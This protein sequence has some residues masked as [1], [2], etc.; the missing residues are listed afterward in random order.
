MFSE[1]IFWTSFSIIFYHYVIFILIIFIL[2]E[3]KRKMPLKGNALPSV[4]ILIAA[5]NEE[6][7]IETKILN[8]LALDYPK[9]KIEIIVIADGSSDQT[10]SIVKKY[11]SENVIGLFETERRG[12]SMAINRGVNKAKGDVLFFTDANTILDRSCLK[13][14]VRNFSDELVGGV[15]GKKIIRNDSNRRSASLGDQTFWQFESNLK[16]RE[17]QIDSIPTGDGEVFAI[18]RRLFEVIPEGIINDDSAITFDIVK[19]GFR[20]VYEPEA[21]S[22]EEASITLEDDFNVKARMVYGGLQIIKRYKNFLKRYKRFFVFQF[23]SHKV[24]RY[25]MPIF[26]VL[27]LISNAFLTGAF[28]WTFFVLQLLFYVCAMIGF[29]QHKRGIRNA[30]FYYPMYYC[31]VNL[32]ALTGILYFFQNKPINKIWTK[33]V[34]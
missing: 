12:K 20:V 7:V 6:K 24:L 33:A 1:F 5:Y 4:S 17:S 31:M 13:M 2:S 14:L 16:L 9:D 21:I 10:Q 34:R 30:I 18:R 28:Y 32:A 3:L 23:F 26:L 22:T 19:K 27:I 8:S 15:C 11:E 29:N 25:S